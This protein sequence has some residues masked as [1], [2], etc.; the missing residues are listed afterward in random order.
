M[1]KAVGRRLYSV[2]GRCKQG[3]NVVGYVVMTPERA[4]VVA[5][6]EQVI[7][8]AA[9][10]LMA[11]CRAYRANGRRNLTGVGCDLTK[12]PEYTMPVRVTTNSGYQSQY[13]A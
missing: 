11:N 7:E 6:R 8:L 2:V 4:Q 13:W 12:L 9:R 5:D 3:R 10:G 1:D